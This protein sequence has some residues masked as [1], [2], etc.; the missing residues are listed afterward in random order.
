[1]ALGYEDTPLLPGGK[2][3]VHDGR[4]P[5]PPVIDPG[6]A[7]TDDKAG[8]PPSDAT[9]VFD[10]TSLDAWETS[11]DSSPARWKVEHGYMEVV[12]GAGDIR[13]REAFGDCQLHLEWA[14]PAAVKGDGQGRGNSGVFLMSVYEVQV[15][16]CHRNQTYPD[17]TTAAL[18]GQYPPLVN[19]CRKPG[20]WQ[21]YDILFVAPRF[22]GTDLVAPAH[23]TVIQNGVVV[24]HHRA[25]QGPTYH[26]ALSRYV[27]HPPRAPLNL[28]DHGDLVRYRNIWIR[29]LNFYAEA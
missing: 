12:P 1:M 3:T 28:Q 16:D 11:R 26:R 13:T 10:G 17:G 20:E 2:W 19:A 14:A 21:S 22:D 24:Q 8:R 7:S 6:T 9:V 5:Q 23:I 18:Y 25:L 15:L 27:P 29:P 4:R